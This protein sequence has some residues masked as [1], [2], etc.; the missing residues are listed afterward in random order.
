MLSVGAHA[1]FTSVLSLDCPPVLQTGGSVLNEGAKRVLCLQCSRVKAVERTGPR[2][3]GRWQFGGT[4]RAG[5][6]CLSQG[7]RPVGPH[8]VWK[9]RRWGQCCGE[10]W[11]NCLGHGEMPE[12]FSKGRMARF[13]VR[14]VTG[15]G[16]QDIPPTCPKRARATECGCW[17]AVS[18]EHCVQA[19]RAPHTA[20]LSALEGTAA[21][22]QRL[23]GAWGSSPM[24]GLRA[25]F[26]LFGKFGGTAT[27]PP[28]TGV[29]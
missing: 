9:S 13:E 27:L 17:E 28:Q 29:R 2:R 23:P 12:G 7:G 18:S 20:A 11:L 19:Q 10:G 15:D 25:L 1:A 3:R 4:G 8:G 26:P 16:K 6:R 21:E 22:S 5:E 14:K 24:A